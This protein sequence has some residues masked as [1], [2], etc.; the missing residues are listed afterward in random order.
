MYLISLE[1]VFAIRNNTIPITVNTITNII[2][3]PTEYTESD[4]LDN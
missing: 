1:N 4:A 2:I 3:H